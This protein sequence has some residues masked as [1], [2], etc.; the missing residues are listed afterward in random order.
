MFYRWLFL[1]C[2]WV[3]FFMVSRKLYSWWDLISRVNSFAVPSFNLDQWATFIL[4]LFSGM[5]FENVLIFNL[6]LNFRTC[7][8]LETEFTR[9]W[10]DLVCSYQ[11]VLVWLITHLGLRELFVHNSGIIQKILLQIDHGVAVRTRHLV[12]T[13][14]VYAE[15]V[16]TVVFASRE[17]WQKISIMGRAAFLDVSREITVLHFVLRVVWTSLVSRA[18]RLL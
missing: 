10:L 18:A 16:Q 2:Q 6:Q 4:L 12:S 8:L 13:N 11:R 14:L 3:I 15:N 5:N 7:Y 17:P 1:H 9:F